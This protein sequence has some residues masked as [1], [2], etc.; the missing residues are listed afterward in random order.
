MSVTC[1]PTPPPTP[2]I[3]GATIQFRR[4]T[5]SDIHIV[6]PVPHSGELILE[7]DTKKFKI[8]DGV[9]YYNSLPY[10]GIPT[11]NF[12]VFKGTSVGIGKIEKIEHHLGSAPFLIVTPLV[13]G[14]KFD[15]SY[16]DNRYI[17]LQIKKG[18]A[19]QYAAIV[20]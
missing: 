16:A 6:N 13:G 3:V 18:I 5:A 10:I 7:S 17:Y 19:F 4:G 1:P 12:N 11:T 20:F 2:P 14:A 15:E 8:G 9:T